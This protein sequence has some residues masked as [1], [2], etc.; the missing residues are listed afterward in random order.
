MTENIK[1]DTKSFY[2]YVR[3]RSKTKVKVGPLVDESGSTISDSK[4]M[5]EVLNNYFSS[6]FTREDVS[7]MVEAPMIFKGTDSEALNNITIDVAVVKKKIEA[8]RSD[9]APGP[10]EVPPRV[11]RHLA[12]ELC[13]PLSVIL[14]KSIDEG[15]A[16]ED[17]KQA[18][19]SPIFKKG[20]K[21]QASNYRPVSLTCQLCKLG[22]SII[23]EE[24]IGHLDKNNLINP[25]QHG[26]GKG[27]SCLT[28]LLEF[29]DKVT[30]AV[31]AGD[32]IDVIY[33][34]FAKAFDMVPHIRLMKK[35]E[36]H[37]IRHKVAKWI[38]AWLQNRKQR[39]CLD[40]VFSTW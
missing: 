22:E 40:G 32:N 9:K 28:N 18:N 5:A 31:D 17:W 36:A 16:P 25:S 2:A 21:S 6:V 10:D 37:G 30:Q 13:Y 8:L 3:S 23:R 26:F 34:D 4:H 14:Q 15:V 38:E 39:V 29:L 24:I 12:E 27:R 19:V 33:L 20:S 1:K 35:L 11:L 7:K